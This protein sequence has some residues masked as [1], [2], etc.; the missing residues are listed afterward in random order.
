MMNDGLNINLEHEDSLQG[1]NNQ[2]N[3]RT[4][5]K[6]TNCDSCVGIDANAFFP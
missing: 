2:P 5:Y 3:C 4:K 1:K 6:Q